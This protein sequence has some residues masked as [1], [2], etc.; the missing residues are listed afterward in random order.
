MKNIGILGGTF[1]P[2]HRGHLKIGLLVKKHF[3][4]EKII[5]IPAGRPPHKKQPVAFPKDRLEMVKIAAKPYPD[6][7]VSDYEIKQKGASYSVRTL[8]YFKKKYP[9]RNL[10]FI[11][12]LDSLVEL[13]TWR[14]PQEILKLC[15]LVVVFRPKVTKKAFAKIIEASP[16]KKFRDKI[17][18]LKNK[19]INIS[20]T[21]IR[22]KIISCKPFKKDLPR[23]VFE[24]ILRNRLY[25]K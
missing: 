8:K 3:K 5:F 25:L 14:C 10:F 4:L 13:T 15:N 9:Q 16:F 18:Y 17:F 2:P 20:S 7:L 6:F 23:A 12:G 11:V 21:E 22:Q 1:D 24:Y 19:G